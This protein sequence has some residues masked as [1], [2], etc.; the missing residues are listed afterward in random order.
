MAGAIG[1]RIGLVAGVPDWYEPTQFDQ[2]GGLP[3]NAPYPRARGETLG[4]SVF[5]WSGGHPRR[6]ASYLK[7]L[8]LANLS[9]VSDEKQ[10]AVL[11]GRLG[12]QPEQQLGADAGGIPLGKHEPRTGEIPQLA[13]EGGP[14]R[15]WRRRSSSS[16]NM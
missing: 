10:P 6:L 12:D 1:E 8:G 15:G 13:G 4:L 16:L 3:F 2:F 7:I 5:E 9:I 14:G 11:G